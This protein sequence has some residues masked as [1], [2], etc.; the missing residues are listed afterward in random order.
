MGKTEKI[1]N[2]GG[3]GTRYGVGIRKMFLKVEQKQRQKQERPSC[4]FNTAKRESKGIFCCKK[5]GARFAGGA[6]LAETLSGGII[7]KMVGQ[8]KFA[9]YL[10]ELV[11]SKEKKEEAEKKPAEEETRTAEK[12]EPSREADKKETKQKKTS[13]KEE[14]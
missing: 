5:C 12:K 11:E 13:R 3:F 4:G 7:K 9:S 10:S 2:T 1:Y 8:K 14:K 6:Y